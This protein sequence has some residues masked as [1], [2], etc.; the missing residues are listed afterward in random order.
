MVVTHFK[1]NVIKPLFYYNLFCL[2]AVSNLTA[3]P[4]NGNMP[5]LVDFFFFWSHTLVVQNPTETPSGQEQALPPL[6]I[7][8]FSAEIFPQSHF[9]SAL[10]S[11][12]VC[13]G[14]RLCRSTVTQLCS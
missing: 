7:T 6:F 14:M 12:I 13:S 4:L 3:Q 8:H 5:E 9:S 1:I 11:Q 2:T 10:F